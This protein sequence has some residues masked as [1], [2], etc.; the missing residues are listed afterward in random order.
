MKEETEELNKSFI[1]LGGK[2]MATYK[3]PNGNVVTFGY[4]GQQVPMLQGIYSI[5]LEEKIKQ[6]SN[7][8][9]K[10]EGFNIY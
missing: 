3:F 10:W 8:K 7:N 6:Y 4:N 5:E 9:T 2:V 1:S